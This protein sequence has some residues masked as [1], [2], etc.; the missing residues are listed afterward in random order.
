MNGR[1]KPPKINPVGLLESVPRLILE[2]LGGTGQDGI[3]S[4]ILLLPK[5]GSPLFVVTDQL[6][7]IN[8]VDIESIYQALRTPLITIDI[9][10]KLINRLHME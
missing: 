7:L 2:D 3:E 8:H 5:P 9:K 6:D 4:A 1:D 10:E